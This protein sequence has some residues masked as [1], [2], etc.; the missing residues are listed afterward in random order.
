LKDHQP[1]HAQ[2]DSDQQNNGFHPAPGIINL[3][4]AVS[5]MVGFSGPLSFHRSPSCP[6]VHLKPCQLNS[7]NFSY[8][9]KISAVL[10]FG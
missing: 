6:A 5:G 2:K 10:D 7:L 4:P 8:L 9:V 1:E 3:I